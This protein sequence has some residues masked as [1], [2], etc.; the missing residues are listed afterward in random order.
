MIRQILFILLAII[1]SSLIALAGGSG[2]ATFNG[3]PIFIICASVSFILHWLAFI[4]AYVF[5]TEHYFDLI[6]SISYLL[7][8]F[9]AVALSP[10][11]DL[12]GIIVAAMVCVWAL[13]LGSFLFMRVKKAGFDRRF[14]VMKTMFVRFLLTWTLGGT[15][16]FITFAAGL[17]A[18]TS[19]KHTDVDSFLFLGGLLWL[20]GFS[21]E[22]IADKQKT[23]FRAKTENAG[24]FIHTGLWSISRHPNYFGEMMLWLGIAVIALP[25]LV[26]WQF[27]TLISPIFVILLISRVSGVNLLE[28]N[29][30]ERWGSDSEYQ[31]YV[32]STPVI[33]P[34]FGRRT[35]HS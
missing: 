13:R 9:I 1:F 24:K 31:K 29:A 14:T 3:I 25:T 35:H 27:A 21:I 15:W 4:P 22:V 12:R 2:S 11:L 20:V 28:A 19:E 18:I 17:T 23:V 7:A 5:Q 30:N 10:S 6:G 32:A 33:V 26:G 34:Y 8:M 16:V